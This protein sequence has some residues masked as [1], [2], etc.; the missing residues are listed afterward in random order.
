MTVKRRSLRIHLRNKSLRRLRV[1]VLVAV[2]VALQVDVV[3]VYTIG[4]ARKTAMKASG[5]IDG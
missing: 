5:E 2:Q 1:A 4:A 3:A